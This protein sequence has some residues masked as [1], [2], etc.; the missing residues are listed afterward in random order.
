MLGGRNGYSG[1]NLQAQ[2]FA[3]PLHKSHSV[4][5]QLPLAWSRPELANVETACAYRASQVLV[6]MIICTVGLFLRGQC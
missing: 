2:Q 5:K 6:K 3:V 4:P 1:G